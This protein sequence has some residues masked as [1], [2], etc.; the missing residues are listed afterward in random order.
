MLKARGVTLERKPYAVG[1][2]VQ[3]PQEFINRSQYGEFADHP[4]LEAASYRLTAGIEKLERGV[5]SFC[6]CPGGYVL[7]AS[8]E[9]DG[10]VVNGMSN[11]ARSSRWAN[12][13]VVVTVDERDW[14]GDELAALDFRRK[15][16]TNAFEAGFHAGR[17][18]VPAQSV[19]DFLRHISGGLPQKSG[20]LAPIVP[21]LLNDIFPAHI[22]EALHEGLLRFDAGLRNFARHPEALL[23]GVESRTSAPLRI[24]RDEETFESTSHPGLYPIGEGAGYA[25]GITSAAVDGLRAV[26]AVMEKKYS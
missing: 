1:L 25:G 11:R 13:A 9:V 5:Y 19:A 8:T 17:S 6:M 15:L 12:S 23:F 14:S 18:C 2:R 16:E 3:H 4:A 22:A 21:A 20:C 10:M 24:L 26:K 7:P